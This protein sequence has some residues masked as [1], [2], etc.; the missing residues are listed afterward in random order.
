MARKGFT[1][2]E[3]INR[4][5]EAETHIN[6]GISIASHL[7]D[8]ATRGDLSQWVSSSG[9]NCQLLVGSIVDSMERSF[10]EIWIGGCGM[11][12][13]QVAASGYNT[14]GRKA[15][16]TV[17]IAGDNFYGQRAV[18]DLTDI[19][20]VIAGSYQTVG[21][22]ADGTVIAVGSDAGGQYVINSWTDITQVAA[23]IY[24]TVG[25]KNDGTVVAA[26]P[27]IELAK[28][29]L[30]VVEYTLTISNTPSGSVITPGEGVFTY[31]AGVM[32]R[33]IAEPEKGYRLVNWSGD[34]DTIANVNAATTVITMHGDYAI[35]ANFA[36][37]WLLIGGIIAA[38]VV[39]AG[40]A[41]FFVRRRRAA[42]TERQGR[43]R[44]ARK[45][46]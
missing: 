5:R 43:R 37:N 1:P 25:R 39:A 36:V 29:N 3:I 45:K 22:K 15:D 20:Q 11:E 14:V 2:E 33:L 34:V 46:H 30:G 13:P 41:I 8:F 27:D 35:T 17:V 26:G 28:W 7:D 6:Q 4:L 23:G 31:N 38:V 42:R 19:T 40:L 10:Q 44:A 32:A 16:S 18:S 21:L 9:S 12:S 24:H